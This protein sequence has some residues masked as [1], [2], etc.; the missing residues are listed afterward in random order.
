MLEV[1]GVNTY[2]GQSHVLQGVD[3]EVPPATITAVLGRN[4]AGKTTLIRSIMGLTPPRSGTIRYQGVDLHHLPPYEISRLG[5]G[6]V[7]QGRRIFPSLT[8]AEN[9]TVAVQTGRGQW[10]P[11]RVYELFPRLYE[12]RNNRGTQLSGGE[13]QMLAL[14]RALV[15]NPSLLLL[16]EPTEGL[17][18]LIVQEVG[19]VLTKLKDSG[20]TLLLVEQNLALAMS[21]AQ[22]VYLLDRGKIVYSGTPSDL[23]KRRD[24]TVRHLGLG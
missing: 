6:L 17:A 11:E 2:Y 13:Q 3:M 20:L 21:I 23:A 10:T 4:G 8:V 7:P 19:N 16:D 24:L 18:P 12:R 5:V 15:G 22:R 14:G 9:L 1:R